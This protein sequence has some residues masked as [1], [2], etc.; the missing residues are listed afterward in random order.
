MDLTDEDVLEILNLIEQS[1]FDFFQLRSGDLNLTVSKGGYVPSGLHAPGVAPPQQSAPEV[2]TIIEPAPAASVPPVALV[3]PERE[4]LIPINAPMVGTFY[5]ASEPGAEPFVEVG[6]RVDADTTVGLVEVMKV[7]TSIPA[8]IDGT[9][10][11]IVV[12]NAEFVERGEV[13]F[14]IAPD[15]AAASGGTGE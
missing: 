15:D 11:E 10:A 8:G 7:F 14:F 6:T 1:H 4:G 13:L 9:I 5:R 2:E 12:A 3:T